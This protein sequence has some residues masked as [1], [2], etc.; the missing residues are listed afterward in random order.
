[1]YGAPAPAPTQGRALQWW[2]DQLQSPVTTRTALLEQH[3]IDH[4]V[5]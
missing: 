2:L 1:M 5:E 3:R 4:R